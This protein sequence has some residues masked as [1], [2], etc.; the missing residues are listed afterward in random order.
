MRLSKGESWWAVKAKSLWPSDD[1]DFQREV[2]DQMD[3]VWGDRGQTLVVIGLRMD[4]AQCAKELDSALL[5]DA[6]MEQGAE[7]WT[8][9]EDPFLTSSSSSS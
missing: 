1:A 5:T 4:H 6:E 8:L 2:I 3:P 7:A 9:L